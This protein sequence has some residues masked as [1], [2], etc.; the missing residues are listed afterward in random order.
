MKESQLKF[1]IALSMVRGVGLSTYKRL[2]EIFGNEEE[3]LNASAKSLSKLPGIG[4]AIVEQ[5]KHPQLLE[6]AKKELDYL[7]KSN[8]FVV[9]FDDE[10]FP[11]RLK[12]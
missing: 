1:K 5:L 4:D 10:A 7:R 12:E 6:R 11:Y 2:T 3:V 8:G 9:H